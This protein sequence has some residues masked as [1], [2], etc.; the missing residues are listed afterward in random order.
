MATLTKNFKFSIVFVTAF[1]P[2]CKNMLKKK[3]ATHE[4]NEQT[5]SNQFRTNKNIH[6]LMIRVRAEFLR[7]HPDNTSLGDLKGAGGDGKQRPAH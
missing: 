7:W 1:K 5:T 4:N 3:K 2:T 6:K